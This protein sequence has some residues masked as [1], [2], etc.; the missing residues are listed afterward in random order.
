MWGTSMFSA[1]L[2]RYVCIVGLVFQVQQAAKTNAGKV[3]LSCSGFSAR[4]QL[5]FKKSI[6]SQR[7][8]N[9]DADHAFQTS[10]FGLE[11]VVTV[12]VC[13]HK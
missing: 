6:P 11:F 12:C 13:M 3:C 1:V 2:L 5:Q 7:L 9:I 4:A 10:G 8:A